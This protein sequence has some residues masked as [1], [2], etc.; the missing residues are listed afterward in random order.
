MRQWLSPAVM[1]AF[2]C[3]VPLL[4]AS[5][6]SPENLARRMQEL[7]AETQA[8]RSELQQLRE[9]PVRLPQISATPASMPTAAM[10]PEVD[11]EEY[12][13]W[14]ELQAEMRRLAWTKDEVR[15]VPYGALWGSLIYETARTFPQPY[16]LYVQSSETEGEDAFV[17]DTRRTRVG[18]DIFGPQIC[19]PYIGRVGSSGRIEIDLHGAFVVENKPGVLFRH[20][21]G[22]LK[23]DEY[24]LMAGQTW[25]LI[26]P[27]YPGMLNYSVGWGGGNIGY[28]RAQV[29]GERYLAFSDSLLVTMQGSLNQNIVSD[30]TKVA[31]VDPESSDWPLI[32]GRLGFTL[33]PRGKRCKP[34]VFGVSGHIGE[35]G[36]DFTQTGPAPENLPPADD[37][38]IRTWS[39]NVDVHVPITR[40]LGF[41]GE[42]FTGENL[43]TFL[44]G[45]V[46]GVNLNTRDGIRSN[47]G[48]FEFWYD[49]TPQ[50][51]THFGYGI[52]DPVDQD[53]VSGRTYNHFIFANTSYD[54][55][56]QLNVGF[57][58]SSWKTLFSDL[59]PGESV[60]FEFAGKYAF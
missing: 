3:I 27:L 4:A 55:T 58:V 14:E 28:R 59:A 33:G 47:G 1:L 52:D 2:F 46:Q 36:F 56:K 26:S 11:D 23:N 43:N 44:G 32:E 42:F 7:E 18:L 21:Y 20:A 54:L 60:R 37:M 10:E 39:F 16:A 5:E 9:D 8:L 35:Q 30:F 31:G 29:R 48:W 57:E 45:I 13:T 22:D 6:T 17:I 50:L 34:I 12:F 38:R 40:R 41:Q 53:V 24:R 19:L 15:V 25:D 49:L 51:H